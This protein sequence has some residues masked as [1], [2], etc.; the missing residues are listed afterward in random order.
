MWEHQVGERIRNLRRGRKL[1]MTQFG[2]LIGRSEQY[3]S[4]IERGKKV[5]SGDDIHK[6]CEAMEVSADFIVSG[7]V[8]P[9]VKLTELCELSPGQIEMTFEMV[10]SLVKFI[11]AGGNNALLKEA[12]RRCNSRA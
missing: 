9:I 3:V 2:E 7:T 6:I 10:A 4:R 5:V 8:H 11:H 12:M 1:T